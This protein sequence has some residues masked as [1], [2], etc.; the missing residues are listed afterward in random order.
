MKET[1]IYT[2]GVDIYRYAVFFPLIIDAN[3]VFF[4]RFS[5]F[6]LQPYCVLRVYPSHFILGSEGSMILAGAFERFSTP[7]GASCY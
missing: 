4:F 7:N 2:A 1:T 3:S 6:S 5:F